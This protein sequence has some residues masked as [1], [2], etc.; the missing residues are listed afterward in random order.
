MYWRYWRRGWWSWLMQ[1]S[2]SL[3]CA[4]LFMPLSILLVEDQASHSLLVGIA[5]ILLIPPVAGW[6]FE[7]FATHSERIAR[8]TV[9]RQNPVHP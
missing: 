5:F 2:Q 1:L 6:V 7:V 8:R 9:P 3:I 4:I